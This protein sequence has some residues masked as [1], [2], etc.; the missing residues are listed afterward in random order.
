MARFVTEHDQ[1]FISIVD[2]LQRL[3]KNVLLPKYKVER[4][5]VNAVSKSTGNLD[6]VA[7]S[8][9][10]LEGI[11]IWGDVVKSNIVNGNQNIYC[12]LTFS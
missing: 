10:N 11:T 3:V 5:G 8:N 12:G 1:G 6:S 9:N 7:V 2:E 4:A